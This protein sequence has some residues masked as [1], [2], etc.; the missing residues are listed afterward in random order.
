MN[1]TKKLQSTKDI[2]VGY[3][4]CVNEYNAITK[5]ASI[6]FFFLDLYVHKIKLSIHFGCLSLS[7]YALELA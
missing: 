4:S 3:T 6:F 1:L 5:I 7:F 2:A